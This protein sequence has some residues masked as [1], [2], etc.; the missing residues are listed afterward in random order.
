MEAYWIDIKGKPRPYQKEIHSQRTSCF[1]YW[2]DGD[3][4]LL[5]AISPEAEKNQNSMLEIAN[6]VFV[7]KK[8]SISEEVPYG[9]GITAHS[10]G[11]PFISGW[12]NFSRRHEISFQIK[13]ELSEIL[14]IRCP[15][16]SI[17]S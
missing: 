7:K 1:Y 11:T 15:E 5:F 17:T 3:E 14:G 13:R 10:S 8:I 2:L 16:I 9:G 6:V 12:L 4:I